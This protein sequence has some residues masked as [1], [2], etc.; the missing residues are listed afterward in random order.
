MIIF[1]YPGLEF[2][3]NTVQ[4]FDDIPFEKYIAFCYCNS[5]FLTKRF[6]FT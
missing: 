4:K 6:T 5:Y 1:D 3:W 2:T